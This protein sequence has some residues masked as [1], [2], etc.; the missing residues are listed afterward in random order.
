MSYLHPD[1]RILALDL[2]LRHHDAKRDRN[3]ESHEIKNDCLPNY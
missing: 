2:A 1:Q 3:I